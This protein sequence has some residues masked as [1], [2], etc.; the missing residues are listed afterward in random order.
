LFLI[1]DYMARSV[2]QY[3][4]LLSFVCQRIVLQCSDSSVS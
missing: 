4:R 1:K 2:S 3:M